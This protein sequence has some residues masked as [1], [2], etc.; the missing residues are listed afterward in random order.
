M[1]NVFSQAYICLSLPPERTWHKVN[2]PKVDYSGDLG[3]GNVGQKPR[4]E[5][6]LTM[7]VIGPL[8]AMWA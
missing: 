1:D 5:P 4:L 7:L 3:G 6:Y 8:S 2:D